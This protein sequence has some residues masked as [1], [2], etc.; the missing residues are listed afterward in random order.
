M[1]NLEIN[2]Q[3]AEKLGLRVHENISTGSDAIWVSENNVPPYP[4]D[5][6]N[7]WVD[8]GPLIERFNITIGTELCSTRWM[9]RTENGP[10]N[11]WETGQTPCAA[12]SA[13]IL[14]L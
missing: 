5:F 14:L 9:A 12:I 3:V 13:L 4:V 8:C 2:K 6:V 10:F 1:T 11:G 7:R